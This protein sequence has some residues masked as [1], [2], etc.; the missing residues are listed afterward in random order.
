MGFESIDG[1]MKY[2]QDELVG[3]MNENVVPEVK[4]VISE[5]IYY[6]YTEYTPLSYKRRMENGGFADEDNLVVSD[7]K[8]NKNGCEV[9]IENISEA[10][11]YDSGKLLGGIIE[12]GI[13]NTLIHPPPRPVMARSRDR[14][15]DEEVVEIALKK[16]FVSKGIDV[17]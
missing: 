6:A 10:V 13:Y 8:Q 4:E 17:K 3:V 7:F 9:I 15:K 12:E 1:L 2:L 14:I 11:G 5:E 16:G